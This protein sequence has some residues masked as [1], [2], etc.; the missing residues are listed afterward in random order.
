MEAGQELLHYRLVEQIGEGGMGVVWK[1]RDTTLD[2]EVA[3]KILPAAF[4]ADA[5]RRARF[6]REARLLASLNH[7]H[8]ATIHGLH[9]VD[10]THFLAME[11]VAGDDLSQRIERGGVPLELALKVAGQVAEALETA[12]DSGV[13][14][15]DLKPANIMLTEG[16]Q[17]R[18]LDFGLA[19]A[20]AAGGSSGGDLSQSPTLTSAGTVGGV[21][22]GTA[23]YMSPEQARGQ[24][25]DRR[26]DIWAF[27]CVLYEMLSGKRAFPASNLS[28]ALAAILTREPDMEQLPKAVPASIRHLLTRCLDKDAR[29]RLRDIGEARVALSSP[30][31]QEPAAGP[32]PIRSRGE[33]WIGFA[34]IAVLAGVL[35]WR[36]LAPRTAVVSD[37]SMSAFTVQRLTELPGPER[38][39]SISPDGRQLLYD[40][41]VGG[42]RDIFLLRVGG[43]RAINLTADSTTD[44][45]QAVF[46]PDGDS[47]AFRSERDGGGLFVMGATGESVRRVTDFGFNPAWSPDGT[48]LA[49]SEE[50]VD[51]PYARQI[52]ASLWTRAARSVDD[53][54]RRWRPR[55]AD[56]GSSHRLVADLVARRRPG[57]LRERSWREHGSVAHRGRFGNGSCQWRASANHRGSA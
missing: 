4:A 42:N 9:E 54:R 3:I 52:S 39:P 45:S 23:S 22:L 49:F 50:A 6:E 34:I 33:R 13:I 29:T 56:A 12:H 51:D 18:I 32:S 2:R 17:A 28:D 31:E 25:V 40:S 57:L 24:A 26:S 10:G 46:S 47:I 20:L 48:R 55:G 43:A 36:T 44:D 35:A 19:K 15:R 8:I 38:N 53:R 41:A 5:E 1:A 14:H 7:P 27:G 11:L 21:I 30:Q 37:D 16:E